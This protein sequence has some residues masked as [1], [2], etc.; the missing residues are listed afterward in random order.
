[1]GNGPHAGV[2]VDSSPPPGGW[3]RF[4]NWFQSLRQVIRNERNARTGGYWE[5]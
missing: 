3:V 1:M 5:S 2:Q 4:S